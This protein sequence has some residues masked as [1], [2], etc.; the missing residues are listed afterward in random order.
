MRCVSLLVDTARCVSFFLAQVGF[1]RLETI[2]RHSSTAKQIS[3]TSSPPL[4]SPV[5]ESPT[6]S[7]KPSSH[8]ICWKLGEERERKLAERQEEAGRQRKEE[9][10]RQTWLGVSTATFDECRG[11]EGRE[12]V[13]ERERE[14]ERVSVFNVLYTHT[15]THTHTHKHTQT[16]RHLPNS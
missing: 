12:R 9:E 8:L 11:R 15:H 7:F 10:G 2:R 14:R 1:G 4:L 5:R 16:R 13:R 6:P 3:S